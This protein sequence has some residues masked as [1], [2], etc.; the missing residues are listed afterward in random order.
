MSCHQH[1]WPLLRGAPLLAQQYVSSLMP[2]Y[3][4]SLPPCPLPSNCSIENNQ[5]LMET[6]TLNAQKRLAVKDERGAKLYLKQKLNL[7]KEN[8]GYYAKID[9][10]QGLAQAT[11]SAAV[12][13]QTFGAM[14]Q[15]VAALKATVAAVRVE[16]VENLQDEQADVMDTLREIQDVTSSGFTSLY[17]TDETEL[18]DELA[19]LMAG[20]VAEPTG[21]AAPA[22]AVAAAPAPAVAA[23]TGGAGRLP[24][25]PTGALPAPLP[26]VPTGALPAAGGMR[27]ALAALDP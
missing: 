27:A 17:Q 5:K 22:A 10:L 12:E 24:E 20:S 4:P 7:Q 14:Q 8:E 23:P 9:N 25:V 26:S 6:A 18:D 1:P 15:G 2:R 21:V 11:K 19:A 3:A 16:D 13:V